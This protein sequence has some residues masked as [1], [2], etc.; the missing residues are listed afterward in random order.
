MLLLFLVNWD[1]VKERIKSLDV[2]R[3]VTIAGMILVNTPGSW[4]Y[5]YSPL[6]HAKWN[7]LTPTDLIFPFFLFIVGVSISISLKNHTEITRALFL[8]LLKRSAIL[9]FIGLFL[10]VF[11]DFNFSEMRYPGVLQRIGVVF[12]IASLLFIRFDLR[13]LLIMS[14]M[15][16]LGYWLI[17]AFVP[18]PSGETGSLEPGRNLAAWVD[19]LIL[20]K[21]VWSQ[22]RIWDPEGVLST[23]LAIVTTLIGVIFGK[24]YFLSAYSSKKLMRSVILGI[25]LIVVGMIWDIYFP[26]NKSL[27]TSSFVLVTGGIAIISLVLIHWIIDI[28]KWKNQLFEPFVHFGSNAIVVYFL[29]GIIASSLWAIDV[30]GISLYQWLFEN[31]FL[32]WLSPYNAS[33][34]FAFTIVLLLYL[35]AWLMYR[36]KIFIKV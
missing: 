33:L 2:F 12:L 31:V 13:V 9:V 20:G 32:S 17:M 36:R 34:A 18:F 22:T 23:F 19:Q 10:G 3:G 14:F 27:W 7:G 1:T 8:K 28:R 26:I 29:S 25:V 4:N 35:I 6:L 5:V 21:H 15:L 30:Y 16:L 11:P 24:Y